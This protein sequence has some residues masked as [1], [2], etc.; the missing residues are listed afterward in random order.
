MRFRYNWF[1]I[2]IG[3]ANW[4]VRISTLSHRVGL[5]KIIRYRRT[6]FDA[7][8]PWQCHDLT[9]MSPPGKLRRKPAKLFQK[10]FALGFYA[11]DKG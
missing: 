4:T 2:E 1:F 11:Q 10:Y 9:R 8:K 6:A 7:A 3:L 5:V